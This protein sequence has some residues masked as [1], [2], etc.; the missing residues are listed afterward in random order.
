MCL[1]NEDICVKFLSQIE[2]EYGLIPAYEINKKI[3]D[4]IVFFNLIIIQFSLI[5]LDEIRLI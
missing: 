5:K 1:A 2:H 3:L 4:S